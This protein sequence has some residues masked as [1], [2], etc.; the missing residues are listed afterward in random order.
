MSVVQALVKHGGFSY[1]EVMRMPL[2]HRH[3]FLNMLHQQQEE[4]NRK[5]AGGQ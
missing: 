1:T 4:Q 5:L 3:G 2:L